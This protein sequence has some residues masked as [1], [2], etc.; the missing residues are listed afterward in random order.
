[1]KYINLHTHSTNNLAGVLAIVNKYPDENLE[2]TKYFSTGIHPWKIDESDFDRQLEML[3][4]R[5]LQSRCLA[6]GECGLDKRIEIPMPLQMM[7]FEQQLIL[8]QQIRKPVIV[9]CVAAFDELVAIKNKLNITVPM[10]VHGFS[11]NAAVASMLVKQDFYLSLGKHWMNNIDY[12]DVVK[13]IP[14]ERLFLE[15]DAS[16]FS[17]AD[18]YREVALYIGMNVDEFQNQIFRNFETVFGY[19]DSYMARSPR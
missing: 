10:V 5:G 13:A 11:K 17:L 2:D 18:L 4:S 8:A 14:L 15:T 12:R 7:V 9:H 19:A 16:N 1:M 6:I 3:K